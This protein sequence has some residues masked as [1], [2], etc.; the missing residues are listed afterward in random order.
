MMESVHR[1]KMGS[2]FYR[3]QV[4]KKLGAIFKYCCVKH[5]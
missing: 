2:L 3:N 4:E 1:K 5:G